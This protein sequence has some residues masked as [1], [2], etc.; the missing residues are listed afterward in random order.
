M[1][2][3]E[4]AALKVGDKIENAFFGSTG[5][6]AEVNA[7]GVRLRWDGGTGVTFTYTPMMTAWM[8]WSK[9]EPTTIT[10]DKCGTVVTASGGAPCPTCEQS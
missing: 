4:F 7:Q 10:C 6:V 2:L 3:Q 5:E 1:N 9:V 8:H